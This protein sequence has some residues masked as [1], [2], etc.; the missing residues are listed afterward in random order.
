MI[1]QVTQRCHPTLMTES[2]L[3]FSELMTSI[4]VPP[5]VNRLAVN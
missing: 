1:L 2:I 4:Y 5:N 3:W